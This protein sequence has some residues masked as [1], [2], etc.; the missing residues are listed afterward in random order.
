M[1]RDYRII[2][3]IVIGLVAIGSVL[4]YQ[5]F[6]EN[7]AY[8][9]V[10]ETTGYSAKARLNKFLA[11]EYHLR[12]LNFNVESDSN[13]A[14]LLESHNPEQTIL[15]N[16]YGPK[17]SP[18]H[19]AELIQWLESGGHL[20]FTVTNFQYAPINDSE[21]FSSDNEANEGEYNADEIYNYDFKNN[22]LLE[23]YGIQGQYTN[24]SS[25]LTH[26]EDEVLTEHVLENGNIVKL[27]FAADKHLLDL[28]G[29]ASLTIADR[30]GIH[31][32]QKNVGQGKL[33]ILSDNQLFDNYSIG[34]HDHAYFLWQL[35]SYSPS[36]KNNILLLYNNKSDSIFSLIWRYGK[37][38]CIA[39]FALILLWLWSLQNRIGPILH[40]ADFSNRNIV[41]HLRAIA[42]FSWRQDRGVTLLQQ[43]RVECENTLLSR[44]STL[45]NMP[46]NERINHLSEVLD[47]PSEAIHSALYLEPRSTSEYIKSTH[48]LQKIWI[49]Q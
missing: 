15:V 29:D 48:H 1:N 6:H 4:A 9:E 26:P 34:E 3:I 30:Y 31:L 41:E 11:A 12:E 19:F 14:R 22:Q 8:K 40:N 23:K 49:A 25:K 45:K 46:N 20:I 35:C 17:L 37:E 21:I 36:S 32:L 47:M 10:E 18:T 5:W 33:T 38:A 39:F 7:Y 44:Y 42:R 28:N 27:K 2:I 24:F 16:S 43:S 13:R